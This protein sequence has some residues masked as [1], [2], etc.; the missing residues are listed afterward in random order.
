[1][2][3][4]KKS[5]IFSALVILSATFCTL[6]QTQN[7]Y[8]KSIDDLQKKF[9]AQNIIN[10]YGNLQTNINRADIKRIDDLFAENSRS[11]ETV[12]LPAGYRSGSDKMTCPAFFKEVLGFNDI[13][14]TITELGYTADGKQN[15]VAIFKIKY[16]ASKDAQC[17]LNSNNACTYGDGQH[18]ALRTS[19]GYGKGLSAVP[20]GN[21]KS[22]YIGIQFQ[23]VVDKANHTIILQGTDKGVASVGFNSVGSEVKTKD[24]ST[25]FTTSS[26]KYKDNEP[27]STIVNHVNDA[28][29]ST[30]SGSWS[31]P[32]LYSNAVSTEN[33]AYVVDE[34]TEAALEN[35]LKLANKNSAMKTLYQ[36]Y[37]NTPE[38]SAKEQAGLYQNYL[39][40][41]YGV[42]YDK[43]KCGDDKNNIPTGGI[44]NKNDFVKTAY[45]DNS[46]NAK[47]CYVQATK[48]QDDK[49]YGIGS[50]G[51]PA[52]G[53]GDKKSFENI[54]QWLFDN[55]P[56]KIGS[57]LAASS[58]STSTAEDKEAAEEAAAAASDKTCMD[59]AAA[60]GW[61]LCPILDAL[62]SATEWLYES[63]IAP[64]LAINADMFNEENGTYQRWQIFQSFANIIFVI[65]LLVV[66]FSQLT[67][68]GIDNYGIKRILPRLIVAAILINLSYI[69][70]QLAVDVSNILGSGL[71][72]LFDSL[73]AGISAN[74]HDIS[75]ASIATTTVLTGI[76]A[77][78]AGA[79]AFL[80]SGGIGVILLVVMALLGAVL[81]LLFT[82]VL[83]SARQAVVII[84][85]VISPVVFVMYMLPNTKKF[86]DRLVHIFAQMLM[87]YP[88]CGL[89]IGGGNF[90]SSVVLAAGNSVTTA[91]FI[92]NFGGIF[93]P[94]GAVGDT[95]L[96]MA[97]IF[98]LSAILINI[99]PFFFIPTLVRQS[100]NALGNIGA[101]I[102]NAT[103][104]LSSRAKGAVG[105]ALR[106]SQAFRNAQEDRNLRSQEKNAQKLINKLKDK[107]NL[108]SSQKRRL[109]R[110][111]STVNK[112]R[113]DTIGGLAAARDAYEN[114]NEDAAMEASQK[115]SEKSRLA[116]YTDFYKR[117]TNGG[118]QLNKLFSGEGNNATGE[119]VDQ[120]N[121]YKAAKASDNNLAM[122]EAKMRML[123]MVDVAG[124]SK[125]QAKDFAKFIKG[126]NFDADDRE[127]MQSISKQMTT[128]NGSKNY[129]AADAAAFEWAD[130]INKG[131]D[132][133]G[134]K[135]SSEELSFK[136]WAKDSAH[137]DSAIEH[138]ITD[139]GELYSQTNGAIDPSKEDSLYAMAG[140]SGREMLNSVAQQA[141]TERGLQS[142]DATKFASVARLAGTDGKSSF[143]EN[144]KYEDYNDMMAKRASADG[145]G[146]VSGQGDAKENQ[147]FQVHDTSGFSGSTG[148]AASAGNPIGDSANVYQQMIDNDAELD[149][150]Q[151]KP[152][153][154]STDNF[155]D[156]L[157]TLNSAKKEYIS[158]GSGSNQFNGVKPP[159]D[160][161]ASS[162]YQK[163]SGGNHI[164]RGNWQG[165]EVT[166]NASTGTMTQL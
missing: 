96:A 127:I 90:A 163:D 27:F 39:S 150:R 78:L 137:I 124:A 114:F 9:I 37:A 8:A 146:P 70:C 1:M 74:V 42:T 95:N 117:E 125:F 2:K 109:G 116:E 80:A 131:Q 29:R 55:G 133:S 3:R 79:G 31:S 15:S 20:T 61:I 151:P 159:K 36:K 60:L 25:D 59:G 46:G 154:T 152:Q 50:S 64:F 48:H 88:T 43:D 128:G 71:K 63:M 160:F 57:G 97:F 103:M 164:V 93:A 122:N 126:Q 7:T 6:F 141:T 52:L 101:R 11:K 138:H 40:A 10:C 85:V 22:D 24:Y 67:G 47:Y 65:L 14:Q 68:V 121:N 66:I 108:S 106:N 82:M 54:A 77:G 129:R 155:Q 99:I 140:A 118:A 105:S 161:V 84:L 75:G 33:Y 107:E 62:N 58:T 44:V 119:W 113:S 38:F 87:L 153:N 144:H 104:G 13:D 51:T 142:G 72:N 12:G 23:F 41:Y 19:D 135:I 81:S 139:A 166:W 120:L 73:S 35:K 134:N 143:A 100:M 147:N 112:I 98:Q 5:L 34:D 89:L 92:T 157:N 76:A 94:F 132:A 28:I 4:C 56:N 130:Q 86:F 149:I 21:N 115:A 136:N 30:I 69:I 145:S 165:R 18:P 17:L 158:L 123:A 148:S 111:Y 26:I 83:L 162:G 156:R 32:S 45:Y 110:A 49:V 91:D 53:S 102:S 16:K